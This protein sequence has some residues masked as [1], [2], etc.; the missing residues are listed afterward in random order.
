[1]GEIVYVNFLD[2]AV[3][4]IPLK[5]HLFL[6]FDFC[7]DHII[8]PQCSD[9]PPEKVILAA[10]VPPVTGDHSQDNVIIIVWAA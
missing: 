8:F 1:M 6:L 9:Q 10:P 4:G 3:S 5:Q 7:L 2:K